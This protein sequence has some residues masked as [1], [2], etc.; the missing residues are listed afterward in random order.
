MKQ[1][2]K[3]SIGGYPFTLERDA[4]ERL[5][6]YIEDIRNTYRDNA[7]VNEITADIEQRIAE[8]FME[9]CG[10]DR[11][12]DYSAV[13][14]VI[15]RIGSPAEL[16]D[17]EKK[18]AQ[19]EQDSAATR[20][21][22][23]KDS[24]KRLFRDRDKRVLG[25][26]CSGLGAYFNTDAVLVR[27]AYILL[28]VIMSILF[29]SLNVFADSIA[30]AVF[31]SIAAYVILWIIIP[32]ARTVEE[33]CRMYRKPID[34][35]QFQSKF[36]SGVKEAATEV[37]TSP[38]LH[39]IGRAISAVTGTAAVISGVAILLFCAMYD[40]VPGL[41]AKYTD[42][43]RI[44]LHGPETILYQAISDPVF[45]WMSIGAAGLLAIWAIYN[46]ILLIFNL[47]APKWRPGTI[48]FILFILSLLA[49]AAWIIRRLV[50][51]GALI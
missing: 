45:W 8:L 11:I 27:L 1:T 20:D 32:A 9:R 37:R 41:M 4:Y 6:G 21:R 2:E 49:T 5:N 30:A 28:A 3:V 23:P 39:S 14:T 16:A 25:G 50:I 35:S 10:K 12:V 51:I 22:S 31:I 40:L 13:D 29:S 34:I 36:E 15:N 47:R 42:L 44:T 48:I 43:G 17:E 26:V 46:G 33:K 19:E 24:P 7:Y 18:E 38:A